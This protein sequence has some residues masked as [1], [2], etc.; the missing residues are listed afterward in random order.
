MKSEDTLDFE[1]EAVRWGPAEY[2][3]WVQQNVA[4]RITRRIFTLVSGIGLVTFGST[5]WFVYNRYDQ[6]V[7]DFSNEIIDKTVTRAERTIMDDLP[8]LIQPMVTA[9]LVR[10]TGLVESAES[11]LIGDLDKTLKTITDGEEFQTRAAEAML[12]ALDESAGVQKV[13]INKALVQASSDNSPAIRAFGLELYALLATSNRSAGVSRDVRE[14]FVSV[15][16]AH[17]GPMSPELLEAILR[18]YPLNE[19]GACGVPNECAA[20]DERLLRAVLHHVAADDGGYSAIEDVYL[21]FFEKI[22]ATQ[23]DLI[24]KS[25]IEAPDNAVLQAINHRIASTQDVEVASAVATRLAV[26]SGSTASE[27]VRR[28]ALTPISNSTSTNASRRY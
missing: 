5:V 16:E 25:T 21:A 3:R 13:I 22:N 18:Y 6:F 9:E 8:T 19:S 4:D 24:L 1:K 23:Y 10:Q 15:A 27:D 2:R 26:Y 7:T 17:D 14:N 11:Q 20:L 28:I 12:N